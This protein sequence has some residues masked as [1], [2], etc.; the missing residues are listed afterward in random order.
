MVQGMHQ[1][2]LPLSILKIHVKPVAGIPIVVSSN[3]KKSPRPFRDIASRGF[4]RQT[5]SAPVLL[6]LPGDENQHGARRC[7]VRIP[8]SSAYTSICT[9]HSVLQAFA[10]KAADERCRRNS[11]C[12]TGANLSLI[13][14]T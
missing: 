1:G 14:R 5:S 4:T 10:M 7:P 12:G 3:G 9:S 8:S 11:G 6:R 13:C 2:K